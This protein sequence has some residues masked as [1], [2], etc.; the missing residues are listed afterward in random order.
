MSWERVEG[1][2]LTARS[3]ALLALMVIGFMAA[4]YRFSQGLGAT[5]GLTDQYPWGIW[6]GFDVLCGVAVTSGCFITAAIV[7]LFFNEKCIGLIRPALLTAFL[8]YVFVVVGVLFDLGLPWMVWHPI[9]YWPEQSPMFLVAW[10]DMLLLATLALMFLPAVFD[11]FNLSALSELW[12]RLVPVY[13]VL[14]LSF[15][16]FLMSRSV[17][18]A[19]VTFALFSLLSWALPRM[20][21]T[22]RRVPI[23]LVIAAIIFS[24]SHQSALGSLF[25]LMPDRLD[26]L[27]W[28]PML[29]VNFYLSSIPVGMAMVIFESTLS[30]KSFHLPVEETALR[31]LSKV[32]LWS[33]WIYFII[34]MVDMVAR[35]HLAGLG[36]ANGIAFIFEILIGVIA[37]LIMFSNKNIV[38]KEWPRFIAA[39]LVI[40]GLVINRFNVLMVGMRRPGDGFYFPSIEEILI[41]GGIIATFLFF[42]N[43]FVRLF[44]VVEAHH[45]PVRNS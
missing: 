2:I 10:C 6:V 4:V 28:T 1:K 33:M 21:V 24:G 3:G 18:W 7:Y 11:R 32:L 38:S 12:R 20:Y 16:S 14:S 30:S 17:L 27:W 43:A 29:P 23:L 45:E 34:R 9:F 41:T 36:S 5:T 40:V 8:G 15:F 44:P 37:P 39:T 19:I 31:S 26:H 42:Y 35:W 22:R 25:L 13:V